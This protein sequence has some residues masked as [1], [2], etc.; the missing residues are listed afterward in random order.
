MSRGPTT[1]AR[2]VLEE[3][4]ICYVAAPTPNGPHL[5]PVVYAVGG[6]RMWM[7]TARS[8]VKARA[9]RS[10]PEV[11]GMVRAGERAVVFRG[12]VRTYDAFDPLTWPSAILRWPW[13]ASAATRFTLRNARFFFGYA[14]DATHV[15]LAWA[16]PGRVFVS[17]EMTAGVVLD[18]AAGS[19][20]EP[21]GSWPGPR[22]GKAER[23][24]AG[25]PRPRGRALDLRVPGPVREAV[26]VEGEGAMALH[27]SA[28]TVF[29]VGWERVASAG[30]YV[31]R[32]PAAARDLAEVA[33]GRRASTGVPAALTV[34]HASTWRAA[35]MTGMLL[36]GRAERLDE[37]AEGGR[38]I[39]LRPERIVWWEGW[40]S[41]TVARRIPERASSKRP[42]RERGSKV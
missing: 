39:R 18:L 25:E 10:N 24:S 17:I 11:A 42:A 8:S 32:V 29:P 36:Q 40:R 3:G 1:A 28:L 34:D 12:M 23:S 5:T 15:P 7:T 33:L 19:A 13:L 6:G 21:W 2:R 27:G 26:G 22:R 16:P 14:I 31:A 30:A 20:T 38:A 37:P 41:G 35:D 9:W 4:V